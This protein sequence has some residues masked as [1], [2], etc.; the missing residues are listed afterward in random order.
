M[1]T[2]PVELPMPTSSKNIEKNIYVTPGDKYYKFREAY[3]EAEKARELINYRLD[4]LNYES[5]M[6]K[7]IGRNQMNQRINP[8]MYSNQ[9]I[10]KHLN[11]ML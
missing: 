8:N 9:F 5:E 6:L 1:L 4:K 2:N 10:K 7:N 11:H 3:I